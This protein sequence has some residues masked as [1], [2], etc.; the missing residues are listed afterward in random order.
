[1]V[2][3]SRKTTYRTY[4]DVC[5]S[6]EFTATGSGTGTFPVH[7]ICRE[8]EFHNCGDPLVIYR[9]RDVLMSFD[10]ACVAGEGLLL[11]CAFAF[12]LF[13]ANTTGWFRQTCGVVEGEISTYTFIQGIGWRL[14]ER[15]VS[16]LVLSVDRTP[17]MSPS[18]RTCCLPGGTCVLATPEACAAV[19]GT[20][21]TG[22]DCA[23]VNCP[24]GTGPAIG[25]CCV[26]P[27]CQEVGPVQCGTLGG[28]YQGDGT[29]CATTICPEP[30][31][32]ACCLFAGG[33][34]ELTQLA[35]APVGTWLPTAHCNQNPCPDPGLG[36]CC[37]P[38]FSCDQ[39]AGPGPCEAAGGTFIGMGIPCTP[40]LCGCTGACCSDSQHGGQR[41]CTM[42][43]AAAC[44]TLNNS[45][46]FGCGTLCEG[47]DCTIN[48][49]RTIQQRGTFAFA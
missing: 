9:E 38:D 26:G 5:V 37:F 19:G 49:M 35:C 28:T 32:R 3:T 46:W 14:A 30:P 7:E 23:S 36:A 1:V 16:S 22:T 4:P 44:A 15:A 25:A 17:C 48:P 43:T 29:T 20:S 40:N 8:L 10:Q 24:Q 41:I 34:A 6:G 13:G 21:G 2:Y 12:F 31:T 11:T 39:T 45:V 47:R 33:C 27:S 18:C 42:E